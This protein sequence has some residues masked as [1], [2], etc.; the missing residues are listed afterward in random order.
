VFVVY[1]QASGLT[2]KLKTT[3][4]FHSV[5]EWFWVARSFPQWTFTFNFVVCV[6]LGRFL[7]HV[8]LIVVRLSNLKGLC[9]ISEYVLNLCGICGDFVFLGT[10]F[11]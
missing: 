11:Q 1:L 5:L 4:V 6:F 7:F 10:I 9:V 3:E 2:E 8:L